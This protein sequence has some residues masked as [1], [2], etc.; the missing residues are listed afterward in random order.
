ME[1]RDWMGLDIEG[2]D[3]G[4]RLDGSCFFGLDG[5]F[6]PVWHSLRDAFSGI[7]ASPATFRAL[8]S[9]RPFNAVEGR[10]AMATTHF[11]FAAPAQ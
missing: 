5:K 1:F 3:Y 10:V 11:R 8:H 2:L 6:L 4:I 7:A 9:H